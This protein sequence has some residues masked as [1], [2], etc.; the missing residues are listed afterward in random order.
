MEITD[1]S[2][3]L[4]MENAS[5]TKQIAKNQDSNIVSGSYIVLSPENIRTL[6]AGTHN[7]RN[8]LKV[9]LIDKALSSQTNNLPTNL[10][11]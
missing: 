9:A 5:L 11:N 3:F 8:F 4:A 6:F 2:V 7:T 1:S 10:F